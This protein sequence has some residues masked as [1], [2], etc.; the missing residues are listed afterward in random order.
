MFGV[1]FFFLCELL[2]SKSNKGVNPF[3]ESLLSKVFGLRLI[4][5]RLS[6]TSSLPGVCMWRMILMSSVENV[7]D[8]VYECSATV[9]LKACVN[10]FPTSFVAFVISAT[11]SLNRVSRVLFVCPI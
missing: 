5:S 11:C 7:C 8:L 1:F 10:P 2:G 6:A 9:D 3:P 4:I